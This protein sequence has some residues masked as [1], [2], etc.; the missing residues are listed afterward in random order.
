MC[1]AA[2]S[3]RRADILYRLPQIVNMRERSVNMGQRVRRDAEKKQEEVAELSSPSIGTV[4]RRLFSRTDDLS[5]SLQNYRE[6]I[7]TKASPARTCQDVYA[8]RG[9]SAVSGEYWIDPNESSKK[10]AFAVNC[11]FEKVKGKVEIKTCFK[12]ERTSVRGCKL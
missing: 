4:L 9:T 7:G 10:D 1:S 8:V 6:P 3:L 11:S 5:E 2:L 12:A